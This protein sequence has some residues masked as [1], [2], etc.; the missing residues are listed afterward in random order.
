MALRNNAELKDY[1]A[2]REI[3]QPNN[4]GDCT[5]AGGST[6][7]ATRSSPARRHKS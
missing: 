4:I 3:A 6:R 2:G 1:A 5:S 7:S